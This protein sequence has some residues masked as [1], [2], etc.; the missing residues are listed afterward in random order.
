MGCGCGNKS[1]VTQ[2]KGIIS[3]AKIIARKIWD[4]AENTQSEEKPVIVTKINKP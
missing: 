3:Q 2:P 1:N 4:A